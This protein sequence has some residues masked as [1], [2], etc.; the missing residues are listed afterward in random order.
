MLALRDTLIEALGH[1]VT[2][3]LGVPDPVR[4]VHADAEGEVDVDELPVAEGERGAD[5]DAVAHAEAESVALA[6]AV[7]ST[8]RVSDAVEL[9]VGVRV[10]EGDAVDDTLCDGERDADAERDM[11]GVALDERV[12]VGE[13]DGVPERGGVSVVVTQALTL[14]LDRALADVVGVADALPRG[15]TVLVDVAHSEEDGEDVDDELRVAVGDDE[16]EA[17]AE[18]VPP[19][20]EALNELLAAAVC[21]AAGERL[22]LSVVEAHSDG[23]LADAL[24]LSA[25]DTEAVAHAVAAAREALVVN[26]RVNVAVLEGGSEKD[27]VTLAATVATVAVGDADVELV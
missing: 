20:C 11:R 10:C 15:D 1:G 27:E 14:E 5:C 6:Q 16:S 19:G 2:L 3:L 26:E 21:D 8:P 17:D 24:A 13:S 7:L 9:T 12:A 4:V 23:Q 18:R 22:P 25:P